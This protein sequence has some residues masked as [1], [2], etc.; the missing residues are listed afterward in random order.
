MNLKKSSLKPKE[1]IIALFWIEYLVLNNNNSSSNNSSK[2]VDLENEVQMLVIG[3][4][5]L[6]RNKGHLFLDLLKIIH[7]KT[8]A[9]SKWMKQFSLLFKSQQTNQ[10]A[11]HQQ[12]QQLILLPC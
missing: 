8:A 10:L 2:L 3:K 6:T 7:L 1:I 4:A 5:V 11:E 12:L 9:L